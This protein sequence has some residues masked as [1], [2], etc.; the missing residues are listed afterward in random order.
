M[1]IQNK[2]INSIFQK[3]L[4]IASFSVMFI[5]I[6]FANTNTFTVTNNSDADGICSPQNCSLRQAINSANNNTGPDV[7]NFN[8]PGSQRH[9]IL[10]QTVLPAI[11]D[12]VTINGTTQPGYDIQ[13]GPSVGINGQAIVNA[14]GCGGEA[15]NGVK[16]DYPGL[17]IVAHAPDEVVGN[18]ASGTQIKAIRVENFCVGAQVSAGIAKPGGTSVSSDP[19]EDV[20]ITES[21]FINCI[22][23]SAVDL[24]N[25]LRAVLTK[26]KFIDNSDNLEF[27]NSAFAVAEESVAL[28]GQDSLEFLAGT[29]DSIARNNLFIVLPTTQEVTDFANQY[30][31]PE[32]VGGTLRN[33][34]LI[35]SGIFIQQGASNNIA[36]YN[37]VKRS[38]TFGINL[39][40][41]G[42][43]NII[44]NNLV[45]DSLIGISSSDSNTI[46]EG[47]IVRDNLNAGIAIAPRRVSL[48]FFCPSATVPPDL[49]E[50]GNILNCGYTINNF[51]FRS[52][53]GSKVIGNTIYQN[54]GPGIVV[55]GT[56][57]SSNGMKIA[58]TT[59][60]TLSKNIIFDNLGLAIDLTN[61]SDFVFGTLFLGLGNAWFA[62]IAPDPDGRT[63]ND[64]LDLDLGANNLQNFPV[65]TEIEYTKKENGEETLK[66]KGTLNSEAHKTYRIDFYSSENSGES[67]MHIGF[68]EVTTNSN[69]DADDFELEKE[70]EMQIL[71]LSHHYIAATATEVGPDGELLS[72]SELSDSIAVLG[73]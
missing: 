11:T 49:D 58:T 23:N 35:R 4:L 47:N 38:P 53:T 52:S 31:I 9:E 66:I 63:P 70:I 45:T 42:D 72:T 32:L 55:G 30:D 26:N 25:T 7:I 67:E 14:N 39:A 27:T 33:E 29:T 3:I 56:A 64:Y 36:E 68:I 62:T 54:M 51:L 8:I 73:E 50:D 16:R 69:G 40:G 12:S 71:P 6:G 22:A 5:G 13:N 59:N 41:A 44:R 65:L 48:G 19:I 43:D 60:N 1:K 61:D 20:V 57:V 24:Q 15:E 21:L 17:D 34:F 28:G 37:T 10:L 46:I 2:L 18:D